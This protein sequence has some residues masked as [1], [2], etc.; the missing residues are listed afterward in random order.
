MFA[1]TAGVRGA[2]GRERERRRKGET[3][4]ENCFYIYMHRFKCQAIW[5]GN[6]NRQNKTQ[7]KKTQCVRRLKSFSNLFHD[8]ATPISAHIFD[9]ASAKPPNK[10]K[11]IEQIFI[12]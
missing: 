7:E 5:L 2:R 10:D 9:I 12:E 4:R 11:I 1:K 6:F 8:D 3:E